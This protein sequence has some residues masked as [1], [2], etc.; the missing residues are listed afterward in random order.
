[1]A[2]P[3]D[4]LLG[5]T[6]CEASSSPSRRDVALRSGTYSLKDKEMQVTITETKTFELS[7]AEVERVLDRKRDCVH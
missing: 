1:M 5:D 4:L 2:L 3:T 6:S 7:D